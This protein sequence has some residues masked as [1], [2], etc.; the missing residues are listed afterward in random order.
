MKI[1]TKG[2]YSLRLLLDLAEHKDDG[3]ISLKTIAERQGISKRYLDQIM[4]LFNSTDYLKTV[5]GSQGGYKLAKSPDQYTVGSILRL[6]E[7]GIAPL[8]CLEDNADDCD[9]HDICSARWVWQGLGDAM[10][11]YLDNLTLQDIIDK[12]GG[13]VPADFTL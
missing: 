6:T 10:A 12:S 9:K 8:A 3:Y 11:S 4:M 7:G 2:R 5:R 1:S 13:K